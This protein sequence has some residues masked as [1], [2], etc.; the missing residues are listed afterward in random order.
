M[1]DWFVT[2]LQGYGLAGVVI[3]ALGFAVWQQSKNA[4]EVNNARLSE[5]DVLI[6]ALESNTTAIRE[7][8]KVTEQRNQVTQDLAEAISKQAGA[9]DIFLQ[10][11]DF[12]QSNMKDTLQGQ[13]KA[14][15]AFSESNR[16]NSGIL[17]DVRDY[18]E[19]QRE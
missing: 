4:F 17:R 19:S 2:I 14:L 1:P 3:A 8:A 5:R 12:S 15:E 18:I 7:N 11:S 16:V 10:K 9:F 13:L 6:K